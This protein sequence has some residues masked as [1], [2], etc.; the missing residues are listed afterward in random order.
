MHDGFVPLEIAL[1]PTHAPGCHVEEDAG[2]RTPRELVNAAVPRSSSAPSDAHGVLAATR[3][4]SAALADALALA[5]ER[6]LCD[7]ARDVLA[8]ELVLAPCDVATIA[9]RALNRY[10]DEEPLRLRVHPDDVSACAALDVGI[11]ADQSLRVGDAVLEVRC[12]TI[13]ASME[14][15]LEVVLS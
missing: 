14:A 12:G 6:L 4:F 1:R 3:R 9:A 10:L 5:L 2:V 11:V 13:D 15:R 7:I 8:R